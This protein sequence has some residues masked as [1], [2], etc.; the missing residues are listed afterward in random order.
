V[1]SEIGNPYPA[2]DTHDVY[3]ARRQGNGTKNGAIVVINDHESTTKGLWVNSTPAGYQ[4]WAGLTLVNAFN[5][6]QTT[7][8]QADGRVY[9]SAPPRGYAIWV[10]QNE[11]VAYTAPS[12]SAGARM[13][14]LDEA[15]IRSEEVT[16]N[17]DLELFPN[18]ADDVVSITPNVRPGA[19][20]SV[21]VYNSSGTLIYKKEVKNTTGGLNLSTSDWKNGIYV[22]KI[23]SGKQVTSRR[24]SVD[25]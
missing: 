3:V 24:I 7:V 20:Y 22:V 2:G 14:E 1:L 25:H 11:Y 21:S 8:V 16:R 17:T 4:N 9:V 23:K 6:A 5:P 13:S 19:S 18:P 12:A 10:R 15:S